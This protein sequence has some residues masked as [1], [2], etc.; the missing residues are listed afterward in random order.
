MASVLLVEDEA[1]LRD[2]VAEA[3]SHFGH[4]A[5]IA[6]NGV[7]ALLRL[8]DTAF[9]VL[10]SDITM[11]EEVS[12]LDLAEH[13]LSRYPLSKVILVSGHAR[14]QLPPLPDN[15]IFLPKPYRMHQLLELLPTP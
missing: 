12:G 6:E 2:L 15:V 9:D 4:Q 3:L 7:V 10:I 13:V 14:D 11:P 8:E 5:T 1:S